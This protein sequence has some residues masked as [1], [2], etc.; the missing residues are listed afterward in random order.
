MCIRDS[1]NLNEPWQQPTIDMVN[2]NDSLSRALIEIFPRTPLLRDQ[3]KIITETKVTLHFDLAENLPLIRTAKDMLSEAFRIIIK[4]AVEAM[5]SGSP[6]PQ[7]WLGTREA[8]P[9]LIEV[10]IRDNGP[11]I[12]AENLAH[13]FEMGWTTKKGSGMGLSL[14]HI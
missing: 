8:A 3:A 7:I 2:V 11:G 14:I 5:A 13:I 1:D 4:N 6:A 10:T 12:A 9:N